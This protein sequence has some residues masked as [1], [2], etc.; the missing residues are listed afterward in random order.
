M[1]KKIFV[2]TFVLLFPL[3][4]IFAVNIVFDPEYPKPKQDTNI[5]INFDLNEY[6]ADVSWFVDGSPAEK[7]K[8]SITIKAP[9]IGKKTKIKA[10]IKY[11]NKSP[12]IISRTLKSSNI[13]ILYEADTFSLPLFFVAPLNSI[14]SKIY[15]KAIVNIDNYDR[16][17]LIYIWKKDNNKLPFQSG[18]GKQEAI[19]NSSYFSKGHQ[20][21]LEVLNPDN[22]QLLARKIVYIPFS[23]PDITLYLKNPVDGWTFNRS[24]KNSLFLNNK[25]KL[26]ALPFNMSVKNIFDSNIKW[27]WFVNG[28]QIDETKANTP[29]VEVS[30]VD[31][32]TERADLKVS[33]LY[34]NH[35][36]Q[37]GVYT[38]SLLKNSDKNYKILA[39]ENTSA[40]IKNTGG[41]GI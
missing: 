12:S 14:G 23:D 22:L 15:V 21:T 20:I 30:F 34:V 9:P 32:N 37:K 19:I 38:L 25:Q 4:Y 18:V 40:Q 41:F 36:L 3:Q 7:N 11:T 33:A 10:L 28:R 6:N 16:N 5:K 31:K 24:V 2:F 1:A 13:D 26:L 29:Y 35:I 27:Q 39:P 8:Q 17:K